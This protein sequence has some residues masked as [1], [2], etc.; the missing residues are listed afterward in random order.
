MMASNS[1]LEKLI[2]QFQQLSSESFKNEVLK[3]IG[4]I[5]LEEIK[6]EFAT[7][8]DPY[9]SSWAQLK[10]ARPGG[11]ILN[12]TGTLKDAFGFNVDS[13]SVRFSNG[14]EYA[15]YHQLGSNNLPQRKMLPIDTAP[16]QWLERFQEVLDTAVKKTLGK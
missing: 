11:G 9:G 14:T 13:D 8:T 1:D 2:L 15:S 3:E 6:N 10:K 12:K 4:T 16:E 7:E 5:G